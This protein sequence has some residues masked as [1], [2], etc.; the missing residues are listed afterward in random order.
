L[1][2]EF[3]NSY[4]GDL[5]VIPFFIT[6]NKIFDG[7]KENKYSNFRVNKL[8]KDE[9]A[10]HHGKVTLLTKEFGR[11]VDF[12]SETKVNEKG[13]MHVIQA[14]FSMNVKEEIQIKGRTAR[15][16][17]V[18]SYELILC[19]DH[20]QERN[21]E[22][23]TYQ[24]LCKQRRTKTDSFCQDKLKQIENNKESHKITLSFYKK[25]LTECDESNRQDFITEI[26]Q[27]K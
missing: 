4:S 23:T 2:D 13:G 17:E 8:I 19:L 5:G 7:K 1:L 22:G 26:M 6:Q 15:K 25:A 27:F 18:G 16:D 3:Y 20:L 10:G 24:E 12:Q 21:F 14:F 9:Y 11:G